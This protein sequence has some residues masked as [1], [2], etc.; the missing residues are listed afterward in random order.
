[1]VLN[2]C[3]ANTEFLFT[4]IGAVSGFGTCFDVWVGK[5][6]SRHVFK[7]CVHFFCRVVLSKQC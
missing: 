1:V 7:N 4:F 3:A 6:L 5:G 2:P